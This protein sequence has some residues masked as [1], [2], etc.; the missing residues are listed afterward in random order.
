MSCIPTMT[1]ATSCHGLL[2]IDSPLHNPALENPTIVAFLQHELPDTSSRRHTTEATHPQTLPFAAIST[3]I[4]R[5]RSTPWPQNSFTA[6]YTHGHAYVHNPLPFLQSNWPNHA[7][8]FFLEPSST[9]ATSQ[10][11]IRSNAGIA[12]IILVGIVCSGSG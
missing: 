7:D 2:Y 10:S 6:E 1:I 4:N 5:P 12:N 11:N 8:T 9:S 3:T